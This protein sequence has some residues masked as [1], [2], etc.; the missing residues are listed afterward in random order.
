MDL[1][2]VLDC[3]NK[4]DDVDDTANKNVCPHKVVIFGDGSGAV[5]QQGQPPYDFDTVEQL[6]E[7]IEGRLK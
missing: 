1:Q 3:L 5:V 7:L 4:L 6:A 2:T